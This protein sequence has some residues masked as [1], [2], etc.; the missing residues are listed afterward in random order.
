VTPGAQT[1]SPPQDLV[2]L[3]AQ[4][5]VRSVYQPIVDLPSRTVIGYEALARGPAGGAY[6]SPA[7]LFGE[8]EDRGLTCQ[9]DALCRERA[10]EGALQA[11]L[12]PP[13][14]LFVNVE[15]ATLT[16]D[17]G[18][19]P[20]AEEIR[21]GRVRV[22]AEFTERALASRP[23]EILQAVDWLRAHGCGVALDDVGLDRRSLALLP[24]LSPDVVKL[25]MSLIQQQRTTL[26]TAQIV[27]AVAAEAERSGI[28]IVAEGIETEEHL[29]RAEA[30]GATLGQGWYFGRPAELPPHGPEDET[31][32]AIHF[33]GRR[34]PRASTPFERVARQRDLRR[35]DKRL[36]LALSQQLEAE[37]EA[38]GGETVVLST[39]QEASFFTE[40]TRRRYVALGE[41]AG[42][43]GVLGVGLEDEPAPGVRGAALHPADPLRGEWDVIVVSPRFCGAFVARDLGDDGPDMSRRFEFFVTYDRELVHSAAVPLMSRILP[44]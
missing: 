34:T 5:A 21:K 16:T 15:P 17:E 22:I 1:L 30:M 31:P 12:R 18:L 27:N 10:L 14:S 7:A 9:L 38:L 2:E 42:I 35:G 24:F 19:L 11:Q 39:F 4:R 25:D 28:L 43:V 13:F 40:A 33:H 8:A 3:I 36:L 23:A 37:A 44:T 20:F 32:Q 26:E 6:E 29:L 41:H